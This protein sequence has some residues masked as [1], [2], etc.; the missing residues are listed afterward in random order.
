MPSSFTV[1]KASTVRGLTYLPH[2]QQYSTWL[3]KGQ[4]AVI[5]ECTIAYSDLGIVK[6]SPAIKLLSPNGR[7]HWYVAPAILE[8][9]SKEPAHV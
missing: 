6:H 5:G 8:A 3:P 7:D 1:K 9:A 2:G 4:Y